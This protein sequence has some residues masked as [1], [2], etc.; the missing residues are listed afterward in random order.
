MIEAPLLAEEQQAQELLKLLKSR[1]WYAAL[2]VGLGIGLM[3]FGIEISDPLILRAVGWLTLAIMVMT[4]EQ[5][6]KSGFKAL[7][8]GHANMDTL[9]AIGTSAAWLYSILV[10]YMPNMF[11]EAARGVYFEAAV[12]II[13]LMNLGQVFEMLARSKTQSSLKNCLAYALPMLV[14]WDQVAS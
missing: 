14:W 1:S 10:V 7:K 4:G 11:P 6:Y 13:G 9:I 2:G 3:L 5:F 12:M 8:S